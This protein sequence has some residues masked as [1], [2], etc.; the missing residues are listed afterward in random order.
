MF[1]G[2][3]EKN[4]VSA[5][6]LRQLLIADMVK[7][8]EHLCTGYTRQLP[9]IEWVMLNIMKKDPASKKGR[10]ETKNIDLCTVDW[11]CL[12]NEQLLD[13]YHN[14]ICRAYRQM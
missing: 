5:T 1:D 9:I 2:E 3:E 12:T 8:L 13:V 14:V 4:A 11:N 10:K 6:D 7:L